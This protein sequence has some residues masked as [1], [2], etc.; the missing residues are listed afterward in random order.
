MISKK[1]AML[2]SWG[3]GKTS[4]VR[5]FVHNVFE[6]KYLATLG[7]KVDTKVVAV[8]SSE[9]KLMLWDIAGA[10]DNFSVPMHYIKGSAAFLLVIDGSRS[11]S[12]QAAADLAD[13]VYAEVASLPFLIAVNKNDLEWQIDLEQV[14]NAFAHFQTAPLILSTSAKSGENVEAAFSQITKLLA[15]AGL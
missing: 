8:E 1:I 7:V 2:G 4:L 11:D 5:Q 12:L 14:E 9:V 15:E 6:D 10:E 13:K 3:V